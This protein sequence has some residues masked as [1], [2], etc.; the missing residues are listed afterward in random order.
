MPK[1]DRAKSCIDIIA[2][3]LI[4]LSLIIAATVYLLVAT[5]FLSHAWLDDLNKSDQLSAL[6]T[7]G[8]FVGGLLN[9]LFALLAFLWLRKSVVMQQEELSAAKEVF[10]RQLFE[11]TFFG[12]LSSLESCR[13][14]LIIDSQPIR[15]MFM[16]LESKTD[17]PGV[18]DCVVL[19]VSHFDEYVRKLIYLLTYI[20]DSHDG[21]HIGF[22]KST[23][24]S[25]EVDLLAIVAT[26]NKKN[27]YSSDDILFYPELHE[28]IEK[29]ALLD[30]ISI[31]I[32]LR[33]Q[34]CAYSCFSAS[35]LGGI[36]LSKIHV[37]PY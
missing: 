12:L 20:S 16:S 4:S 18:H 13:D 28:L 22:I 1:N 15:H 37:R 27:T 32:I 30:S 21:R 35:A 9:P 6:G 33:Y 3:F 26:L 23:I 8:D 7:L 34:H 5:D 11:Q 17:L 19:R 25:R 14:R 29:Y 36:E 24:G 2:Q 10:D 31:D